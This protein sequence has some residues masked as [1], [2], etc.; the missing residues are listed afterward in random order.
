MRTEAEE[1]LAER[2]D[3][4]VSNHCVE[5]QDCAI[6]QLGVPIE[7]VNG[8]GRSCGSNSPTIPF[9]SCCRSSAQRHLRHRKVPVV[10]Y[11]RGANDVPAFAH[12]ADSWGRRTA[13]VST[14]STSPRSTLVQ[15]V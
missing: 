13:L 10:Q 14:T 11:Q 5:G 15:G 8:A 9:E 7:L 4:D 1:M 3:V 6:G 2:V 12:A